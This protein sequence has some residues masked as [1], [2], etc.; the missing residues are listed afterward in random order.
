ML[1]RWNSKVYD[2]ELLLEILDI[3]LVSMN[4]EEKIKE[5]NKR[6][7]SPKRQPIIYIALVLK[8][9]HKV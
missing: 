9:M 4:I 7:R 5:R 3:I 2:V 8:E 6:G 1:K